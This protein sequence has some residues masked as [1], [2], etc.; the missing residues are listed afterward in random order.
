MMIWRNR[1]A[2]RVAERA[3]DAADVSEKE[4]EAMMAAQK[5]ALEIIGTYVNI[6]AKGLMTYC[7]FLLSP[8]PHTFSP[9]FLFLT[10]WE[11]QLTLVLSLP[12]LSD[13][14]ARR[15]F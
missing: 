12:S 6:A 14:G 9:H 11:L 4:A 2:A 15:C 7:T 8:L 10:V 3:E 5:C 13:D 1:F